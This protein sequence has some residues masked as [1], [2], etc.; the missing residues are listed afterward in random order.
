MMGKWMSSKN[1]THP[2]FCFGLC[3]VFSI[4]KF[5]FLCVCVVVAVDG[6]GGECV[7][8]PEQA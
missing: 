4:L 2:P 7:G 5:Y 6:V 8:A 3:V 1:L